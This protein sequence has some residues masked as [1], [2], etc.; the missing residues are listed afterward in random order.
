MNA[1]QLTQVT[2]AGE[3]GD[4]DGLASGRAVVTFR[5][6]ALGARYAAHRPILPERNSSRLRL[7]TTAS[8]P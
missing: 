6:D 2:L 5:R 1:G 4:E 3:F 8:W 7:P